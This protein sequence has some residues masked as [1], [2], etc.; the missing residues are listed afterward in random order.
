[1]D[2]LGI[3]AALSQANALT[4]RVEEEKAARADRIRTIQIQNQKDKKA[5]T[6]KISS[7]RNAF[8][9]MDGLS[10]G[11]T[12]YKLITSGADTL[13]DFRESQGGI[14]FLGRQLKR[15]LAGD[16][17]RSVDNATGNAI[18]GF[19]N[20]YGVDRSAPPKK[21][22]PGELQLREGRRYDAAA[23][24]SRAIAPQTPAD[25]RIAEQNKQMALNEF[26]NVGEAAEP[27][28][29]RTARLNRVAIEERQIPREGAVVTP[30]PATQPK[31]YAQ[32]TQADRD[33]QA[34]AILNRPTTTPA[35][36]DQVTNFKGRSEFT[37]N[38]DTQGATNVEDS[39]P[40]TP[41]QPAP[42]SVEEAIADIRG[43]LGGVQS[44]FQTAQAIAANPLLRSGMKVIGN[45]QGGEDIYD[46]FED[47]NKFMDKGEAGSGWHEGAHIF[48]SL[49]TVADIA[50][51]FIPG[52]EELGAALNMGGE[53]MDSVGDHMKDVANASTVYTNASNAL[54]SVSKPVQIQEG[55]QTAGLVAGAASHLGTTGTGVSTF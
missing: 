50:G 45:I 7:D 40:K 31:T 1:M 25:I 13:Q 34:S 41:A 18:S 9:A 26:N 38:T 24:A 29:D 2:S 54:A 44:K 52:A 6:D 48:D 37:N 23:D 4:S 32:I 30:D 53:I 49:G 11:E 51:I 16:F 42:G 46:L 21:Y 5:A 39:L 8:L 28:P 10:G 20:N 15:S 36:G 17:A 19:V 27:V 3:N 12:A 14:D 22:Q 47:K 35:L 43:K 55:L 33:T